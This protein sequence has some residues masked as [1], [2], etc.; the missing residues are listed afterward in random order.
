MFTVWVNDD[1][2]SL[3]Q[4]N[5]DTEMIRVRSNATSNL[6]SPL[7]ISDRNEESVSTLGVARETS[8][9]S[10]DGSNN[11]EESVTTNET[12]CS[13]MSEDLVEVARTS[14]RQRR[15]AFSEDPI[16]TMTAKEGAEGN[17]DYQESLDYVRAEKFSD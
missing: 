17:N 3:L 10:Q 6:F 11:D 13:E 15:N 2:I 16:Q 9:D 14:N 5:D 4:L 12:K 1:E 7:N 8:S